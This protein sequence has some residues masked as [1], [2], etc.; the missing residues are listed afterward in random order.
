VIAWKRPKTLVRPED[1]RD[2]SFMLAASRSVSIIMHDLVSIIVKFTK[3]SRRSISMTRRAGRAYP[4]SRDEEATL[5]R[6]M[7]IV[8]VAFAIAS[9]SL[10]MAQPAGWAQTSPDS[11]VRPGERVPSTPPDRV[12]PEPL[13]GQTPPRSAMRGIAPAP[14]SPASI[15]KMETNPIDLTTA[16]NLAGVQNP[17][18][19]IART[20]I[21]EAV[22]LRQLAAAYFLPSINPGM[23]YDSHAGNLQQ[24]DG[25]I[26]SVNRSAVYVGAGANAVGSGTV[27]IPGV[28]LSENI[29]Q[30]IFAYL[31]ARQTV[32]QRE[33]ETIA[34]R[35]QVFLQVTWAY[36]ELLRA[37][38]R[39]A[40][41][42]QARDEARLIAKLT[43]DYAKAGQGREADAN[44]AATQLARREAYI[45]AAEGEVLTASAMLCQILNLDPSIRL[46]PTDAYLVPFPIVPDPVPVSE[47]IALGLLNRP[48]LAAQ[49]AAI[50]A[51]LMNLDGAKVLPFSPTTLV[52]FSAGGFAGGSNLV[53]PIFG[54]MSGRE[55]LDAIMYWTIRNLGAG[56]IAL[57]RLADAQLR[58]TNFHQIEILNQ[59]R[60]DV[61][62]AY[63]RT[64]ARYNQIGM[65]E[66]AV[67][68][69]YLA[70]HEDLD[71]TM[72]MGGDRPRDVLP[73]ELLNSFDLLANARI[74]YID[75]IVD[76]NRAQFAMYVALGQPP[77][78]SLARPVPVEG[79]VPSNVPPPRN[80]PGADTNRP[81]GPQAANTPA[82]NR[83]PI[84]PPRLDANVVSST[85][86]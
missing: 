69:G 24:S 48:E 47:L 40:A 2:A 82:G 7:K 66:D 56:N 32:R 83:Q 8:G 38:G 57:I 37:E 15:L 54:G 34:V 4:V 29:G 84:P 11:A 6:I 80:P 5:S 20:R 41:Q 64:H 50:Q 31:S 65:Y 16:L 51:A 3:F 9:S 12:V 45:Q 75:A 17:D 62:E 76:Y 36:S 58:V 23:N 85:A 63:A 81:G 59:V 77:A 86:K 46:H 35:N 30:G 55:D 13:P 18:L 78:N 72:L 73:I 27:N 61:A 43:A 70:F 21:L 22:A 33:F 67:R 25:N 60:A 28:F 19:N 44:R 1:G 49:R 52:G 14:A 68:S 53:R 71:R 74:E 42:L 26:L 39:R 10:W 79:V